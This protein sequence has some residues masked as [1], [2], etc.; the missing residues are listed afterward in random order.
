MLDLACYVKPHPFASIQHCSHYY[1]GSHLSVSFAGHCNK[2]TTTRKRDGT[3]NVA[4]CLAEN[5]KI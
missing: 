5:C 4:E 1:H 2:S 3:T